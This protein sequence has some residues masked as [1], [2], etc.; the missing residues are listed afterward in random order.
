E[1]YGSL[2][3]RPPIREPGPVEPHHD[4]RRY[5]ELAGDISQSQVVLGWRTVDTMREHTP[6]LDFAGHILAAG[7]SSRLYR[8]LRER[9]LASSVSAYNYS[10][11]EIGVFVVHAEAQP[12]TTVD[13]A[14]A[15]WD[16]V[17]SLREEPIDPFEM[18]RVRRIFDARW[19]RRFESMEGQGN[20]LAD[21]E[22]L[23][24]WQL[25][26]EYYEK[27]MSVTAED[28]HRV[29]AQYLS[30]DRAG[31]VVYRPESAP[32]VAENVEALVSLLESKF[33]EPLG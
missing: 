9:Q 27:F 32:P 17:R 31:I 3:D 19:L 29:V 12:E 21:W 30:T 33:V 2:P 25:G 5:R 23:G 10:P 20:Y 26:D 8:A 4:D 6:A 22:A 18:E 28:V 13:A 11:T 16:Q 14:T 1:H 15:I 7:R 24:D